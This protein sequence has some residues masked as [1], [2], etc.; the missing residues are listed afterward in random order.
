MPVAYIIKAK[1]IIKNEKGQTTEVECEY[2]EKSKSGSNTEESNRRVK[3]TVHWVSAKT[4]V[5]AII[6]IYDRL[7]KV[8]EPGKNATIENEINENSLITKEELVEPYLLE[9]K[10]GQQ[11]QFQRLGYFVKTDNK[12]TLEFNKTVGL[13]D[14]WKK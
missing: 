11:F 7:F 5:E 9:A 1:N 6:N 8:E 12:K 10:E 13:R 4:A 14:G 2:D 3:A